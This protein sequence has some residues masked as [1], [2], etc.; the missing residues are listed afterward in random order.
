MKRL[1]LLVCVALAGLMLIIPAVASAQTHSVKFLVNT[2]SVPDSITAASNVVVTG[3][4]TFGGDSVLTSW[5]SGVVLTNI[6]GDYWT[7]TLQFGDSANIAYKIRIGG[8]GWEENTNEGNGNRDLLV[9]KDTVLS[10][11]FW[12]NGHFPSGKNIGE[13]DPPYVP[14][15]DSMI[16]VYVRVDLK[17]ISDNFLYGWTPADM[18]SVCIL[19]GG[20]TGSTLDW[21]TPNYLV[22]EQVPTNSGSAFGLPAT[23]F[24]SGAIRIPKSLVT[25]GMD[26]PYK[27]R[28]GSNWSYGSLQR[29]EQG[30]PGDGNRHFAIPQGLKDTTLQYVY[31]ADTKPGARSNADTVTVTFRVNMR[32]AIQTGGYAIGDTVEVQ[33]GF[34][35]TA[36][37][38]RTLLLNRLGLSTVYV[39]QE[40]VVTSLNR[41]FDYQYYVVKNGVSVREN[42]YNFAYAGDVQSERERRQIFPA[43][44][45]V[46]VLDT[47]ASS[48]ADRRQPFF[49]NQRNL[50]RAVHV[51]WT[52]DMR[53]AYYQ[54]LAGSTLHDIQGTADVNYADSIKVWGVG[55]NGPATGGLNGPLPVDW[56]TWDRTMVA[57]SSARKMWDDGTHGDKVA[58]DSIY[59]VQFQY[60]TSNIV[61]L[62]YK[63]GIRGG[64]NEAGQGGYGN[65]ELANVS[66]AD[67]I[68]EVDSQFGE[69]NPTFYTAWN[70]TTHQHVTGVTTTSNKP[71]VY[72]LAQNYPNPFNPSTQI[73]FSLPKQSAVTLKVYNILG[74]EVATLLGNTTMTGGTHSVMFNA[75]G[76]ASG[77]YFY[78]LQA[79]S[80]TDVKKM[81]L[82]K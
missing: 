64:D 2:A 81:L 25:A 71:L 45:S 22:Q 77:M 18:D 40:Q 10:V 42:Y 73:E 75:R 26:I 5:G 19:G 82:L 35:S 38:T 67:S 15:P 44:T 65:N 1:I 62:V 57:D 41:S 31:F 37:S 68:F 80:F 72:S 54:V 78:R 11:Q 27:F 29:S 51:T 12:N 56:A 47:V 36:D 55:I 4:G 30:L 58:G 3:G 39:G 60:T 16:N 53:P 7:T 13:F 17:A 20:P 63:F 32:N 34:F 49:P 69:I 74:Q 33:S 52:V 46:T 79:G 43:T 28:L 21:G 66:D 76:L 50:T 8:S 6:G 23:S 48:V 70:F 59:S 61:G 9:L 24:Y 14:G